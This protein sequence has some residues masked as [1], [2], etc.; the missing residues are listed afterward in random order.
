[1]VDFRERIR[2][3]ASHCDNLQYQLEDNINLQ[4]AFEIFKQ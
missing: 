1:M 2:Y 3:C 4:N